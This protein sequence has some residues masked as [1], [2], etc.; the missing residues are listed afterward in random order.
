VKTAAFVL[1]FFWLRASLPRLR[2]DQLMNIGWKFLIPIAM[3]W[4]PL[5]AAARVVEARRW[6]FVAIGVVVALFVLSLFV[7]SKP[8]AEALLAEEKVHERA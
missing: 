6:I 3:V 4:I 2:Y 5:A 8:D 7:P 1:F